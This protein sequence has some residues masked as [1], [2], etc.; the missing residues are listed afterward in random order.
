MLYP[1]LHLDVDKHNVIVVL[2]KYEEDAV[3]TCNQKLT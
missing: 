2:T 3:L 1:V